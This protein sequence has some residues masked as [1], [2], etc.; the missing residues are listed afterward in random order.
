MTPAAAQLL[1]YMPIIVRSASISDWERKFCASMITRARRTAFEPTE[2]QVAV[3][4][5]I[6]TAFQ[7]EVLRDDPDD[8]QPVGDVAADLVA[9]H[10]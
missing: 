8:L 6:V 2:K 3:M 5:R 7:A 10:G 4:Q 9:R 1:H